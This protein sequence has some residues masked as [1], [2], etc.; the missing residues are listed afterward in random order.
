[1]TALIF[2]VTPEAAAG[3]LSCTLAQTFSGTWRFTLGLSRFQEAAYLP[4]KYALSNCVAAARALAIAPDGSGLACADAGLV[5]PEEAG[6]GPVVPEEPGAAPVVP[7]EAG[8]E[9]ELVQPASPTAT[10]PTISPCQS[11]TVIILSLTTLGPALPP[12]LHHG[13]ARA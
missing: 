6:A 11:R 12:G 4:A 2:L 5:V 7:E 8:V 10:K 3:Q 13:R 9:A 1:M